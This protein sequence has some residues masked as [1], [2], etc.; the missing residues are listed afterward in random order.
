MNQSIERRDIL[1]R[2]MVQGVGFR[3]ST[4]RIAQS[5][6]VA[7]YVKNLPDGR[8]QVIVEGKPDEIDRFLLA[9]TESL[10]HYITE[11]KQETL[12]PNGKFSEFGIQL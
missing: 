12:T 9:I 6:A 5:F 10:G 2:G 8:V 4:Q 1:Y 11:K 3:F 7:G